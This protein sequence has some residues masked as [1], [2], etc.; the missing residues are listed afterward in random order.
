MISS[1]KSDND[2]LI[3]KYDIMSDFLFLD[4]EPPFTRIPVA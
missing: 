3:G 4:L 2:F 1:S